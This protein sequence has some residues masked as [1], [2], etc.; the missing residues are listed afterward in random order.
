MTYRGTITLLISK[1]IPTKLL[2]KQ[3]KTKARNHLRE[4]EER[5]IGFPILKNNI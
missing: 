4:V 2:K 5:K 1:T 3:V